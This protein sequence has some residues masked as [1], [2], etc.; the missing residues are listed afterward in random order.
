MTKQKL[1]ICG[2]TGFIGRNLVERFAKLPEYE[3]HA[4]HFN[5]P[6]FDIPGVIWHHADLR[7][8]EQVE[9]LL[10]GVDIVVQAAA[11]TSGAKDITTQP[12]IHVTDNVVMNSLMLRAA[13]DLKLKHFIFFSCTV[14]HQSSPNPLTE[15][16]WDANKEMLPAYFGAGWTKIYIEKMCEFYARQG[17]TKCTVIRHS[18][19]YGPHDKFDLDKSHVFGATVSKCMTA[20]NGV[21]TVW[22]NGEEA[23]DFLYVDD[24]VEFVATVID[25]QKAQFGLYNVGSGIAVS[26]RELVETVIAASQKNLKIEFDRSKPTIDFTLCLDCSKALN[27]IGWKPKTTLENG[28]KL[29]LD[30]WKTNI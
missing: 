25:K 20:D 12:H 15:D 22:G 2:A 24:L 1:L 19:I 16:D 14:M 23:R 17:E 21:V 29:T 10:E 30:W 26:I 8:R 28:I 3:V 7:V 6:S 11:T 18:N 9:G 4:H 13:H 27:D 5:R